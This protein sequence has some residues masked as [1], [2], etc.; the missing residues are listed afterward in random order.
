MISLALMLHL[1]GI[2]RGNNENFRHVG[3]YMFCR[4]R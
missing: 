2:V 4:S 1:A 3:K